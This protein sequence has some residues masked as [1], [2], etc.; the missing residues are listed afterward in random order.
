MKK[1]QKSIT[2]GPAAALGAARRGAKLV[3][4]P[5]GAYNA[6]SK[7]HDFDGECGAANRLRIRPT[8]LATADGELADGAD[9]PRLCDARQAAATDECGPAEADPAGVVQITTSSKPMVS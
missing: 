5:R 9:D 7:L 8:L 6:T 2:D 4:E 3:I 1:K